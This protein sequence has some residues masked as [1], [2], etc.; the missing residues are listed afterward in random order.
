MLVSGNAHSLCCP[1]CCRSISFSK[2]VY[3]DSG[4]HC[5]L[6]H[7]PID[8]SLKSYSGC[9]CLLPCLLTTSTSPPMTCF[10]RQFLPKMWPMQ[11][12]FLRF[13][14]C[15]LLLSSW[16]LFNIATFFTRSAQMI[17]YILL[18]QH[19]KSFQGIAD[20]RFEFPKCHHQA[21]LHSKFSVL[22]ISSWNCSLFCLY[23]IL[24][25]DVCRF[26]HDISGLNLRV[27]LHHLL[28]SYSR[29]RTVPH[30]PVVF[31]LS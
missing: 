28:S 16:I 9:L 13:I 27:R 19:I 17:F 6:F 22:L 20:L 29:R 26:C 8:F 31:Y 1:F 25:L 15:R 7:T 10:A 23:S 14:I 30:L 24:L 12:A 2:A 21:K 11:L 3:R 4:T 18:Q 5:V